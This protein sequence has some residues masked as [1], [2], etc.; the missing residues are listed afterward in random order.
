MGIETTFRDIKDH[1]F[2]LGVA[3]VHTT[4]PAAVTAYSSSL[5]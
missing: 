4:S 1:K 2:G 5:R 3:H